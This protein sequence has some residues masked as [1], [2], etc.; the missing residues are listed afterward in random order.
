[1][2]NT[3]TT[4]MPS[5]SLVS[6]STLFE[7]AVHPIREIE[8]PLIQRDYAQGRQ[9][10]SVRRIRDSFIGT[11]CRALR[12]GN[13][14]VDLDFVF[15]D[16]DLNGKFLPLDGQQRL[17]T[18]FLLHCY[19]AWRTG[20][21]AAAQPWARFSYATRPGARAFCA[22]LV[23]AM[24]DFSLRISDWVRDQ[25]AYLSTWENDPTIQ[26]MLVV[27]DS[28][29]HEMT[30][31][32]P[33]DFGV[34]YQRL[35][36]PRDPAI[37]FHILPMASN[38][39]SDK[40]YIKMNSRGKPLTEF[41]N[42]K[43]HFEALL[44]SNDHARAED[45][46]RKVD[47]TWS[48]ILWAYRGD[49]N[50]IDD[51]FMR[52]FRCITEIC[53]WNA[54]ID[55]PTG[56]R[57]DDLAARVYVADAPKASE[58]VAFL[59]H[60]FELW[61]GKD[62]RAEFDGMLRR[63]GTDAPGAL[64]IFNAFEIENVDLFA[65]CCRHYGA[66]Q[67]T[68]AHTLVLYGFLVN[69]TLVGEQSVFAKRLRILRNLV[70]ASSDE[71]RAGE[72]N[73][74][75]KLLAEVRALIVDGDLALQTFNQVQVRHEL[76]KAAMLALAPELETDLHVLEDHDLLRGGLTALSLDPQ[77]FATR[78]RAFQRL[79]GKA[80]PTDPH[81]RKS[82]TGALLVHGDYAR[83][84]PRGAGHSMGDFGAPKNDEPWRDLFRG[85]KQE[86]YHPLLA[87]LIAVLDQVAGGAEPAELIARYL[88]LDG[89]PK[90]WR[91]YFIKYDAMRNGA[92]G[93]YTISPG[94]G[95]EA[96]MLDKERLTSNYYDPYLLALVVAAEVPAG[97]IGNPGWPRCYT[98]F[99]TSPRHLV[100]S[101]SRMS[102]RSREA[103]W[104]L[105]PP[106]D[107]RHLLKFER[108][109]GSLELI[110]DGPGRLLPIPQALGIDLVDRIEVGAEL[111][112]TLLWNGL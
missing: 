13:E 107:P 46:T 29:N 44:K 31:L 83:R 15:G 38:G 74:M 25:A 110:G 60:A 40:L 79:F 51:E 67:W 100:L 73:N 88:E 94:G 41:E 52:Y 84:S 34:A 91:Y 14:P 5:G 49:D 57:A 3:D 64:P 24:P 97:R 53:A 102:F 20:I 16:V 26:S 36:D 70:E 105:T 72:R 6:F 54:G 87:P 17:T 23:T 99:E 93:R 35:V 33:T 30:Q 111:M 62:I 10:E 109:C 22:F 80:V 98:G 108:L 75:P 12:G 50:L 63:A 8:I 45:F 112:R 68:F 82:L 47:T 61:E 96:C 81:I 21:P 48:D 9:T 28:L 1:M 55:F 103:G 7:R 37:R 42:F 69:G 85:R 18:L 39:L 78:A 58:S 95:Y 43:A 66:R 92:S 56:M 65:A 101:G 4:F 32:G 76:A 90:D 59:F 2:P 71:I 104:E 89:T 11:L 106:D 86:Q 19:L 77:R 27:L